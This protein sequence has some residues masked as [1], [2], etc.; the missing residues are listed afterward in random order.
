MKLYVARH[1]QTQ[2]NLENRVSGRTDIPLTELGLKQAGMLAEEASGL[3]LDLIIAS[4][5]LRA[6][7]TAAVVAKRCEIPMITDER[8]IEHDFGCFEG[9]LRTDPEFRAIRKNLAFRYPGGESSFDVAA[10]VY[11]LLDEIRITC[12]D[13]NVLLV[14]HGA[15]ARVL[16][17]YF[18]DMTNEEF[19]AFMTDNCKCVLYE[20]EDG[21]HGNRA[22]RD[23]EETAICSEE[24]RLF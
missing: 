3:E 8:L 23:G 16:R 18:V 12:A 4:P 13:K 2:W 5:L 11:S 24:K 22:G 6:Q 15:L 19:G 21:S 17:T 7:Q 14:C 1:G 20:T 9:C 10:R